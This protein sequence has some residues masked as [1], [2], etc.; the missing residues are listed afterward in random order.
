[1]ALKDLTPDVICALYDIISAGN[2]F[3]YSPVAKVE[4]PKIFKNPN[5]L[6]RPAIQKTSRINYDFEMTQV[7][8]MWDSIPYCN[9][10]ERH[11]GRIGDGFIFLH[12]S[13]SDGGVGGRAELFKVIGLNSPGNGRSHWYGHYDDE[14]RKP[15]PIV[16][17]NEKIGE[18]SFSDFKHICG[19][20]DR[21]ERAAGSRVVRRL[22]EDVEHRTSILNELR[23][24]LPAGRDIQNNL[25][26]C[27][28]KPIDPNILKIVSDKAELINSE[29]EYK[30]YPNSVEQAARALHMI[31]A[32]GTGYGLPIADL[33]SGKSAMQVL[34]A[35]CLRDVLV[36]QFGFSGN[37]GIHILSHISDRDMKKQIE[38]D[39][40]KKAGWNEEDIPD[41][42][43]IDQTVFTFIGDDHTFLMFDMLSTNAVK[44]V[45]TNSEVFKSLKCTKIGI[46]SDEIQS[47]SLIKQQYDRILLD[48]GHNINSENKST[49]KDI[50]LLGSTATGNKFIGATSDGNPVYV[51]YGAP[52]QGYYGLKE[53]LNEGRIIDN[54]QDFETVDEFCEFYASYDVWHEDK[55]FAIVRYGVRSKLGDGTSEEDAWREFCRRNDLNTPVEYDSSNGNI[56]GIQRKLKSAKRLNGNNTQIMFIKAALRAGITFAPESIKNI[57]AFI[58]SYTGDESVVQS[59]PGRAC[60]YEH[61]SNLKFPIFA[62]IQ[63]IEEYV[64]DM[65]SLK[66]GVIPI[67]TAKPG[68]VINWSV[69]EFKIASTKEFEDTFLGLHPYLSP[70][71]EIGYTHLFENNFKNIA[72]TLLSGGWT[73][74]TNRAIVLGKRNE[75]HKYLADIDKLIAKYPELTEG[76]C[77]MPTRI[78]DISSSLKSPTTALNATTQGQDAR[79]VR[80]KRTLKSKTEQNKSKFASSNQSIDLSNIFEL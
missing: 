27:W 40:F 59:L 11:S 51:C 33:Q 14:K 37:L 75:N 2:T 65:E 45:E 32:N 10:P 60:G 28:I 31:T 13:E 69:T 56:S 35:C 66:K 53:M 63:K 43:N 24:L 68:K 74:Q 73:G 76:K 58:D 38:N 21:Y 3:I 23:E 18:F 5:K 1:M 49:N 9:N 61:R 41:E 46:I 71:G 54:S 25:P 30:I 16:C 47:A 50:Y 8:K 62:N 55:K 6:P 4:Q 70:M 39:H 80:S 52:G 26:I 42:N 79:K 67:R 7:N 78:Q 72:S 19:Y 12:M 64:Q 44:R 36:Y 77:L 20:G 29:T 34:C 48:H 17:F 15:R 57:A 22:D